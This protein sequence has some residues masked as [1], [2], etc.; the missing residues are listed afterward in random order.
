MKC[1]I[2]DEQTVTRDVTR[3]S[4]L[5]HAK[6]LINDQIISTKFTV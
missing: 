6:N 3:Q 1:D 2:K 5:E 4:N